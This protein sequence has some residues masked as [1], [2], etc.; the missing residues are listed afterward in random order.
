[1]YPPWF[2]ACAGNTASNAGG[3]I[4][5]DACQ[6]RGGVTAHRLVNF[7]DNM[8]GAQGG[9]VYI[10]GLFGLNITFHDVLFSKSKVR[11]KA[12]HSVHH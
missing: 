11:A 4:A 1:M 7:T 9:S 5:M 12:C 6:C 8:A 2:L 3:A 10:N